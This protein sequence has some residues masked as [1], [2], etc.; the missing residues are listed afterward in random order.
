MTIEGEVATLFAELAAKGLGEEDIFER[1]QESFPTLSDFAP[2]VTEALEVVL[3]NRALDEV[4]RIWAA[5]IR[6]YLEERGLDADEVVVEDEVPGEVM[7]RLLEQTL[8]EV[9]A[10]ETV[11][12]EGDG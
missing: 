3:K 12:V 8:K 1:L 11:M 4:G 5:R 2:I 7:H 9:A 6:E 10:D